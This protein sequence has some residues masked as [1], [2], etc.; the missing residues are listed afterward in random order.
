M[1]KTILYIE[2]NKEN[3]VMIRTILKREGYEVVLATDGDTGIQLAIQHEP[4]LVICDYHLPGQIKGADI[5]ETIR[6]TPSIAN[7]SILMLTADA[8]TY[9]KS[10]QS[11]ADGY[12]N[13]PVN[14]DQ[15]LDAVNRLI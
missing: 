12:L 13:K 1:S 8:S 3:A 6:Q 14:R 11:G 10:I 9:P 15:L 5:V 2:D 4:V 7:T